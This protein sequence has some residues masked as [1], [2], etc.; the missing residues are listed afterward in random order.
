MKLNKKEKRMIEEELEVVTKTVSNDLASLLDE[1]LGTIDPETKE[2]LYINIYAILVNDT[3]MWLENH[4]E[5][6][7]FN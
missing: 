3:W 5:E 2:I 6:W 4:V 7:R 1:C